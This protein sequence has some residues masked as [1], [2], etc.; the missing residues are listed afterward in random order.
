MVND[1]FDRI[2]DE[3]ESV[4]VFDEVD[5]EDSSIDNIKN[6]VNDLL[7]QFDDQQRKKE[8]R[9][10]TEQVKA[11]LKEEIAKIKPVQKVIE[12]TLEKETVRNVQVPVHVEPKIIQAPPAPPQIIK[13]VRVEVQ[14]EKPIDLSGYAES[15]TVNELKTEIADLKLKLKNLAEMLPMIGGSGVIGIPPPEGNPDAYVL[16]IDSGKAKWKVATGSGGGL[17]P[18]TFTITNNIQKYSFDA[19]TS[20]IDTLYQVLATL[21]RKLQGEI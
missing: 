7:S 10:I 16:T 19:T 2:A 1:I 15:K 6:V 11:L 12:K 18:G 9:K 17:T 4:D 5:Q 8:N 3:E 20:D 14:K 21:I 13:E